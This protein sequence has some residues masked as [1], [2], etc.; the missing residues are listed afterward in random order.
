MRV[1]TYTD[2]ARGDELCRA[3]LTLS[4]YLS[5]EANRSY[6]ESI[7]VEPHPLTVRRGF[8]DDRRSGSWIDGRRSGD[9][10]FQKMMDAFREAEEA[11]E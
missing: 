11:D 3:I 7:R 9:D 10:E 1:I 8:S 6:L 5:E 4:D 2:K